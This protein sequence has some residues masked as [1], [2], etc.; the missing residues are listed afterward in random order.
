MFD[1]SSCDEIK[2]RKNAVIRFIPLPFRSIFESFR[3]LLRGEKYIEKKKRKKRE[4]L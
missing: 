2:T 4:K 3:F 1:I